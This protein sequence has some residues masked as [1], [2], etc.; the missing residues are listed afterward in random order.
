LFIIKINGA[1][2]T[3]ANSTVSLINSANVCN[4]YW[5][6][7]GQVDL[8]TNSVFVGTIIAAGPINLFV[9]STLSGRG[10]S[11]EGAISLHTTAVTVPVCACTVAAPTVGTITQADCFTATGSVVLSGLPAGDWTINPGAIAGTGASTTI[12]GLT[13]GT[14]NYTVTSGLCISP[15]SE[16]VVIFAQPLAVGTP[17]FTQGNSEVCQDATNNSADVTYTATAENS[18]SITYSVL[19]VE[20]GIINSTSGVI[21]W[22]AAFSGTATI[23]ATAA[24]LCGPTSMDKVVTVK[25]LPE[26]PTVIV[27][28]P[29]EAG[30]T[31]TI[32]ITAPTGDWMG[33]SIDCITYTNYT[34][35]FSGLVPGSYNVTDKIWNGCIST[36]TIATVN[37]FTTDIEKIG[38]DSYFDVYPV[39]N[40]GH[41]TVEINAPAETSF[42]ILISNVIGTR[43]YE[44]KNIRVSGKL[45]H[46]I[47]ISQV[48]RGIYYILFRS[49]NDKA[50]R[51]VL[52]SE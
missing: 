22:D 30:G 2:G 17:V 36:I 46:S 14:Y 24:G 41:F 45:E 3:A 13:E 27:T 32:T 18:T 48:P 15:E 16:D 50:I 26:A 49:G 23:T 21:D 40:N 33:Y 37:D 28:Q 29:T 12:S 51:K 11:T 47:D 44:E 4:V 31:G 34:G 38:V 25:P 19:P 10:L 7:N 42:D 39:P 5:Q 8:E 6:I 52:K 43:I 9:G 1:L 20:A 35:V